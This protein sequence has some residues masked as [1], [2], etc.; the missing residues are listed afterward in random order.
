LRFGIVLGLPTASVKA[1]GWRFVTGLDPVPGLRLTKAGRVLVTA[2]RRWGFGLVSEAA[3]LV[4]LA[5][6]ARFMG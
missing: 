5:D 3:D 6:D 2:S 4:L 1:A